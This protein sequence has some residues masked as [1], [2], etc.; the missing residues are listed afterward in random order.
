[1]LW[2]AAISLKKTA[3]GNVAAM[4]QQSSPDGCKEIW[5]NE[6]DVLTRSR[7]ASD[8]LDRGWWPQVE[9][10]EWCGEW[11]PR[12]RPPAKEAAACEGPDADR[13]DARLMRGNNDDREWLDI[14]P[15]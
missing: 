11:Q 2:V 15:A 3:R 8:I 5:L 1:M 10:D 6:P 14:D 4:H 12:R 9:T 13:L 7:C